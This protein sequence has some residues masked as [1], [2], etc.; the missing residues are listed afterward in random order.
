[1]AMSESTHDMIPEL[2][3]SKV[4]MVETC[5]MSLGMVKIMS[6]V[7]PS[8]LT[9]PLTCI[10]SSARGFGLRNHVFSAYLE[11]EVQVGGVRHRFFGNVRADARR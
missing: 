11:R 7:F 5:S 9:A 6:L 10:A 4:M 3:T 1:M 2:H 8:C